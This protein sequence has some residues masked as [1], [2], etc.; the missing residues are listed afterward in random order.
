MVTYKYIHEH[1]VEYD[2][3]DAHIKSGLTYLLSKIEPL[4]AKVYFNQAHDKKSAQ[5][6]DDD[7][8]QFTLMYKGNY[9]Y[10]LL[11]RK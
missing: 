9:V 10:I 5:F 8:H 3:E 4:E 11:S 1:K 7:N 2:T 6:E